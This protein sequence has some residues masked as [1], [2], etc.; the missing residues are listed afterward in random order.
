MTVSGIRRPGAVTPVA[1]VASNRDGEGGAD[2]AHA[3]IT[4]ASDPIDEYA[5]RDAFDRVEV[6]R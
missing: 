4:E 2:L 1:S 5:D 3:V 6:D